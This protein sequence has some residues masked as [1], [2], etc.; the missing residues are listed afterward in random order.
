LF[1]ALTIG[2]D[3]SV[4]TQ[5]FYYDII[6]D[7]Q[8]QL[9]EATDPHIKFAWVKR[10]GHAIMESIELKMGGQKVDKHYGDWLNIWYELS[11]NRQLQEI[12][13]K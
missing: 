6:L 1:N 5:K 9:S 13:Y 10:I 12:Y 4:K 2:I 7:L 8:D 3:K 11:A